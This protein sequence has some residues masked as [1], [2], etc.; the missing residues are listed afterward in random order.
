ML[1]GG[2]L[3]SCL[4]AGCGGG[5]SDAVVE[6][7]GEV[8]VTPA[9]AAAEPAPA[10]SEPSPVAVLPGWTL[11]LNEEFDVAGLP[12]ASKWGF[13]TERNQLGWYNNEKQYYSANRLAN[14]SVQ[15]G[16][17]TITARKESLTGAADYGGQSYTSA[18]LITRGKASWTYGFFEVRAK[19]PCS[20]GTIHTKAYNYTGGTLGVGQGASTTVADACAN[21]HR[22]QLTWTADRIVIG[23]DDRPYF[24]YAK[25]A[26]A[27][28]STWPFDNPQYLLLNLAMGGDLGG[29][30]PV[31]FVADQMAVDYVRVYQK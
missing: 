21:F 27:G 20:L 15:N 28:N 12:D 8:A 24:Q 29:P 14:A 16:M 13:D 11:L 22:Y 10:A 26:N 2:L 23:V 25:P 17:L 1:R 4:L 6:A 31:N 19:L 18:R 3:L 5:G 9:P 30:V 7:A